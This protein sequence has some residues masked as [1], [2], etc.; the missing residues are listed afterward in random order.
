MAEKEYENGTYRIIRKKGSHISKEDENGV[1]KALQFSDDNNSL[2]GPVELERVEDEDSLQQINPWVQLVI[3]NL[4]RPAFEYCLEVGAD[5]LLSAFEEKG[6]PAIKRTTKSVWENVKLYA[7]AIKDAID[8]KETKAERI[9]R[10]QKAKYPDAVIQ[11][12]NSKQQNE[13]KVEYSPEEIQQVL[14]ILQQSMLQT[15]ACIQI[16]TD[17]MVKA[18]YAGNSELA[19]DYKQQLEKFCTKK[20]QNQIELMLEEKNRYLLD[21]VSLQTLEAFNKRNILYDGKYIPMAEFN[22]RTDLLV[23]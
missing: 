7:S 1:R 12:A 5:Y 13:T 10:E 17:A 4:V 3:D 16:L 19:A 18:S 8:G 21:E 23:E 14:Q 20:V 15:E 22:F 2:N 11:Q 6:I 9:M